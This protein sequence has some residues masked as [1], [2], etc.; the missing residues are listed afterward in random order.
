MLYS[1]YF[2]NF[3]LSMNWSIGYWQNFSNFLCILT[4]LSVLSVMRILDRTNSP[5]LRRC[6]SDVKENCTLVYHASGYPGCH[7]KWS[8]ICPYL[9]VAKMRAL[10]QRRC[11][12]DT[13][14]T[15]TYGAEHGC[16]NKVIFIYI[17][18]SIE[19]HGILANFW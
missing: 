10:T 16:F 14:L 13:S 6:V 18:H 1:C 4:V 11:H 8:E 5:C 12:T 3:E 19:L 17:R 7:H 15:A 2:Q 9:D